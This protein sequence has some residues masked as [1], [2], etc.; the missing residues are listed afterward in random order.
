MRNRPRLSIVLATLCL[1]CI[2]GCTAATS[3]GKLTGIISAPRFEIG[4][5]I[6]P[7]FQLAIDVRDG[8][9]PSTDYQF[10]FDR[11]GKV[12]Y[13]VVVRTPRRKEQEGTFEVTEEQV[14][15]LWKALTEARFDEIEERYPA[16][17]IGQDVKR[18][19]QKFYVRADGTERR[20][21]AHFQAVAALDRVRTAALAIVPP[22]VLKAS[23]APGSPKERPKEFIVD[24]ATR[25]IHLP[26][27]VKLKDVPAEKRQPF[28]SFLNALDYG[29]EPCPECRPQ[30]TR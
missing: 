11:S 28:S 4:A 29:N 2:C 13:V 26:D 12:G 7:D 25:R 30:F 14:Q 19:V 24:P 6:P 3:L 1:G 9:E 23:G 22:D 27:C 20:V 15:S 5:Q 16:A 18:G 8:M 17:G 21:E 10:D